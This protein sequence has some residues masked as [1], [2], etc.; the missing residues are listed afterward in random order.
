[1]STVGE[2]KRSQASQ[3]WGEPLESTMAWMSS[4]IGALHR[5]AWLPAFDPRWT[6]F[7]LFKMMKLM[8]WG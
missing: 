5:S 7:A 3:I 2:R 4:I 1:M 8:P 6:T